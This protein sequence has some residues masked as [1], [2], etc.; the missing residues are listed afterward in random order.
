MSYL[1][2]LY[3]SF[4]VVQFRKKSCVLQK[5]ELSLPKKKTTPYEIGGS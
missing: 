2:L 4:I 3:A 1:F 5:S